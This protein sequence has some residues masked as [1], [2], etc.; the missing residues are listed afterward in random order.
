M[1]PSAHGRESTVEV[2][3]DGAT[4]LKSIAI[5]LL[6]CLSVSILPVIIYEHV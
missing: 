3:D 2:T 6:V 5:L 4:I 1:A